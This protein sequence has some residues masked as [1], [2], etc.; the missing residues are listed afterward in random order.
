MKVFIL[1]LSPFS[2]F[3]KS[4]LFVVLREDPE[5]TDVHRFYNDIFLASTPTPAR[6][7]EDEVK[8]ARLG[9]KLEGRSRCMA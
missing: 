4:Y 8:L 6:P 3:T 5:K 2:P 9:M 1:T 7:Q